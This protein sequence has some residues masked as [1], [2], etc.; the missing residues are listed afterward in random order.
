M[1]CERPSL[2]PIDGFGEL[3]VSHEARRP[4]VENTALPPVMGQLRV[5]LLSD[6]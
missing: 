3:R 6:E 1:G 2:R 4:I 5:V